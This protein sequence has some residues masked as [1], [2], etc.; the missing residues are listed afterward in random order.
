[1]WIGSI[2]SSFIE[3]KTSVSLPELRWAFDNGIIGSQ[4]VVDV[5]RSME[6][7]DGNDAN[8]VAQ[9]A[10]VTH[11]D[12][13]DVGDIL[14]K[15][16]LDEDEENAIRSKWAWLVLSW[17]YEQHRDDDD[18][19]Y[20]VERLYGDLR[21]P[22]EMAAFGPYA[23]AYQ[24]KGDPAAMREE[25]VREWRRYLVEGEGTYGRPSSS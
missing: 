15:V 17:L 2:P 13:L 21:Y 19:L 20:R 10:M 8:V 22:S 5:A 6:A 11:A 14:P 16:C 3:E 9:L 7:R 1:M 24:A 4:I 23:P 18:V 12:L 25:V